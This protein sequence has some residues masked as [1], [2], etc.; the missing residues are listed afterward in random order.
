MQSG[1]IICWASGIF[2]GV[3]LTTTALLIPHYLKYSEIPS[4]EE[5]SGERIMR[6]SNGF[7]EGVNLSINK[8]EKTTSLV[9]EYFGGSTEYNDFD[10]D[11]RVDLAVDTYFEWPYRKET[12]VTFRFPL[13][14]SIFE[15]ADTRLRNEMETLEA[16]SSLDHLD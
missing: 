10:S 13:T 1:R 9:Y 11:G 6:R 16:V 12:N 3:S 15:S 7:L 8:I 5:N 14:E 2:L 4:I